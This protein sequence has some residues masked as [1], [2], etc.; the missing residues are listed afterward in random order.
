[1][2]VHAHAQR[3]SIRRRPGNPLSPPA[4]GREEDA[5]PEVA[6]R[7]DAVDQKALLNFVIR[8]GKQRLEPHAH[9]AACLHSAHASCVSASGFLRINPEH[10]HIRT[11]PDTRA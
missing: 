3:V 6:A 8:V 9:V 11:R 4:K 2:Q 5:S 7:K 10:G 1:M